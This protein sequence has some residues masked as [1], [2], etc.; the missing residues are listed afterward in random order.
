MTLTE[1]ADEL[2]YH[3]RELR[4]DLGLIRSDLEV[5]ASNHNDRSVVRA[6]VAAEA[7]LAHDLEVHFPRALALLGASLPTQAVASEPRADDAAI[8]T[9]A[10]EASR[11]VAAALATLSADANPDSPISGVS[12]AAQ[13]S[14]AAHQILAGV[15]D[16]VM[17][18]AEAS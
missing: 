8:L 17:R 10:R 6:W 11:L 1:H 15:Q 5:V 4:A 18:L 13:A 14:A 16:L 3:L 7:L 9:A 12:S 2:E